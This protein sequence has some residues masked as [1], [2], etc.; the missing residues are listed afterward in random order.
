MRND[1]RTARQNTVMKMSRRLMDDG[2]AQEFVAKVKRFIADSCVFLIANMNNCDEI[3]EVG[4]AA[5]MEARKLAQENRGDLVL[6][7][8]SRQLEHDLLEFPETGDI[9]RFEDE[10]EALEHFAQLTSSEGA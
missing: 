1:G 3:D 9:V 4:A 10:P 2:T 8:V 6:T 5:L 7:Y